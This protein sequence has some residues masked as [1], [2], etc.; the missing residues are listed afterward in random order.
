MFGPRRE[1]AG[2]QP[3]V[4]AL[5]PAARTAAELAVAAAAVAAGYGIG[6][7]AGGGSRAVAVAGAAVLGAASVAGAAAVNSVV[8]EVAAVG[9]HNYVAGCDDPTKLESGEVE[10]LA[11]K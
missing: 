3:L 1:L 7:R 9:L 4:E 11:T 5:S 8:P 6:L 2:V 10:A